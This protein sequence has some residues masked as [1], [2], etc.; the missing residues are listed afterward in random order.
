MPR[1][2]NSATWVSRLNTPTRP[3]RRTYQ[4]PPT[5]P[6]WA[7]ML[8]AGNVRVPGDAASAMTACLNS[9]RDQR[10]RV[11]RLD[12]SGKRSLQYFKWKRLGH[13]IVHAGAQRA[14]AVRPK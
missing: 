14:F 1:V 5:S 4:P 7:M 9:D 8:E 13:K 2:P 11:P 6:S 3:L 10:V 12:R